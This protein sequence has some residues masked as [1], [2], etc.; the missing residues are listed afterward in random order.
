MVPTNMDALEWLRKHLEEDGSDVLREM[1]RT[2]AE[3]L[4][5]AEADALCGAGYGERSAGPGDEA[6]RLSRARL[7]HAGRDDRVG[8]PQAAPGQLLPGVAA[9][10]AAAGG[11][12]ADPGDLPVLR[13]GGVDSP[14]R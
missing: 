3:M 11:A 5:S 12:G 6:Q 14:G 10:A 13:G 7:R 9:G 4:M 1:V 8:D 2:F